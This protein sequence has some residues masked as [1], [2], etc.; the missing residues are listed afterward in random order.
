MSKQKNSGNAKSKTNKQSNSGSYVGL[1]YIKRTGA[2]GTKGVKTGG[3][4][5]K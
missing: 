3:R 4:P 1:K 5:K 2:E